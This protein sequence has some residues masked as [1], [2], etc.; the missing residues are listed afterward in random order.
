MATVL[1]TS[2]VNKTNSW[3]SEPMQGFAVDNGNIK[4]EQE[5]NDLESQK[6]K[7]GVS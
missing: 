6:L 7:V 3:A 1:L 2:R 5:G 4:P